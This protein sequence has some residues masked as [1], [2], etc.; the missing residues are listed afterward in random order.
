MKKA[1]A[2][3]LVA[4]ALAGCV[5]IPTDGPVK[6]GDADVAQADDFVPLLQGPT[7]DA[8]PQAIVLGFL[9]AAA[10]GTTLDFETAR[11]Y[12][13]DE[14]QATWDPLAQVTIYDSRQVEPSFD[15]S[16]GTFVYRVPVAATV[17]SSGVMT[18]ASSDVQA[19]VT[20]RVTQDEQGQNRISSLENGIVMSAADFERFFRPIRLYYA[21]SD[22]TT[23]VPELRWFAANDQ[24]STA[25]TRELIQGPSAWLADAVV[26]GFPAGSALDVGAVVVTDGVAS[27]DLAP[28]SAGDA[29]QRI[30]AADQVSLTLKQI[31]AVQEVEVTMGGSP[32][33][34]DD[35]TI[36]QPARLPSENAAVIADGR[37]GLFDGTSV[38]VTAPEVGVVPA[39]A[40]H[41]AMAYD[42]AT[43]AML[44][45]GSVVAS[46]VLTDAGPLVAFDET[47][48]P[49]VNPVTVPTVPVLPGEDL[50]GPSFDTSG[51]LWS[52]ESDSDGTVWASTVGG[53]PVQLDAG[54][55]AGRAVQALAVSRDGARLA[56]LSRVTGTVQTLEV[57]AIFRDAS[58]VPL[59]LGAPLEM[60]PSVPMS[61]DLAWADETSL[62]TLGVDAGQVLQEV[63]GGWTTAE[64][65]PLPAG[66]SFTAR[67]GA[68]TLVAVE[69]DGTLVV[70]AGTTWSPV[71]ERVSDV[72]YEG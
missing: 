46:T 20:F 39:G 63:V 6:A 11:E 55:L 62:V 38:T 30:L 42:G 12:L 15:A 24:I 53:E 17:D 23:M 52:T 5:S 1:M 67:N 25:A 69:A 66:S 26:T 57:A 29:E 4:L 59:G 43:V 27:V 60:S 31:S 64:A 72:A 61:L 41:L 35:S 32:L 49:L 68:R 54:W 13:T 37:L 3:A 65:A 44:V 50:V 2:A 51:W 8:S 18:E 58:G 16:T 10:A 36:L 56:V 70:R 28:G 47:T 71:L 48:E 7:P 34:S 40:S 21:A 33:V 19:D 45:D 22:G 14:A 9:G